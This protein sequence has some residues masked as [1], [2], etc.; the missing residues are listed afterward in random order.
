MDILDVL[1]KYSAIPIILK[2]VA[3]VIIEYSRKDGVQTK[4]VIGEGSGGFFLFPIPGHS[5]KYLNCVIRIVNG[6]YYLSIF[7]VLICS[8]IKAND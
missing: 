5:K 4:S 6:I 7:A 1:M 2:M 8:L 3:H